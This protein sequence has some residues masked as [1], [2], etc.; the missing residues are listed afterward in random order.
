MHCAMRWQLSR[1]SKHLSATSTFSLHSPLQTRT[2]SGLTANL[3][4]IAAVLERSAVPEAE[5]RELLVA[6]SVRTI[7]KQK[8]HAFAEIG[9]GSTTKSLQAILEPCQAE[10]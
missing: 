5:N 4:T 1:L 6:G 3:P 7:R 10:G 8:R 2:L 9:D